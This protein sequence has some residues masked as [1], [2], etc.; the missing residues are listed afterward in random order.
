MEWLARVVDFIGGA[1]PVLFSIVL[2][3]ATPY[4]D[5]LL[6][7][8]KRLAFRVLYNSK[9]GLGPETLH[10]GG[11]PARSGPPQLRQVLRLVDRMSMVVIRIRNNGS[12]D[13]GPD[14]FDTPLSFTFGGRVVWNARVSEAS[15]PELRARLREGLRFFSTEENPPPRDDLRTVRQ[16]LS[17]R[18]TR[19]LGASNGQDIAEP[20][21][22]GVRVDGLRL[23]PG[24]KAKLVVVLREPGEA[25]D[26]DVTKT[27]D[28]Y[29]KLRDTGLIKDEGTRR[30]FTLSRVSGVF[31]AVLTV[32]LVLSQV[33][34][35][36]PAAGTVACASGT[37]R[38][39][40]ST[41]FMPAMEV[42]RD[43]YVQACGDGARITLN[44]NGSRDGV[45]GI[46]EAGP[47]EAAERLAFSDGTSQFHDRL[48]SEKIAIVVY[49]VVVNS[50]VKLTTL[51]TADLRKIYD[52]T[53]TDWSQV[54]GAVSGSLPIRIV[55]RGENSGTRKLFQQQVLDG[56]SEGPISSDLC[57][58]KDRDPRS[59]TIRCEREHNSEI[60]QKIADI[61]GAIGYSDAQSLVESRRA[62]RVTALTLDGRAF[63]ASTAVDTGYPL[64]TVEYAYTK[65]PPPPG[66]LAASFLAF[67]RHHPLSRT[68][69]T[70]AG[71]RP[72]TTPEGPL[73]LCTLR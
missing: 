72:C 37:L 13:I 4:F 53:W 52:G 22:L 17:E 63:D 14:D 23:R 38:I 51:S 15:T 59:P 36:P 42:I 28:Q 39:E 24:Q 40:G 9:I 31:A 73:Q 49:Y 30:R 21:W 54:P 8:R 56:A 71:F 12:Y 64:W 55:G 34:D 48:H 65:S 29:G 61:P 5:R 68:T 25:G 66:T 69:L 1:G 16:R 18:M 67:T 45:R 41:V 27:V 50:D 57:L 2:L 43:Q 10:D 62:N 58:E 6:V 20:H 33:T 44:G 19:W 3:I 11:D 32:L 46:V 60:V 70:D 7:R 35:P 26:G 47:G